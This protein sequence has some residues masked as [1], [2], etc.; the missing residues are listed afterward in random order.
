M[1]DVQSTTDNQI[2]KK[3]YINQYA[4][5]ISMFLVILFISFNRN[6]FDSTDFANIIIFILL[7]FEFLFIAGAM[8]MINK[9]TYFY[10]LIAG[11]LFTYIF[12]KIFLMSTSD[13]SKVIFLEISIIS[14]Y[15]VVNAIWNMIKDIVDLDTSKSKFKN[16]FLFIANLTTFVLAVMQII[17][18]IQS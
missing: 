5:I 3:P 17:D 9:V 13:I 14:V 15:V 11:S 16:L 8:E 6:K 10:R 7:F 18:I 1:N 2:S 4:L 12:Y